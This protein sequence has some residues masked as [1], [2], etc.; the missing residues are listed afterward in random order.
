MSDDQNTLT[1]DPSKV[2]LV[3]KAKPAPMSATP[4][5]KSAS[6]N[7]DS[8]DPS[9]VKLVQRKPEPLSAPE[10][11]ASSF[12]ESF[13]MPAD[14]TQW[15]KALKGLTE[16]PLG[17]A[18]PTGGALNAAYNVGKGAIMASGEAAQIGLDR[19]KQPGWQNK[20]AG[21]TEYLISGIPIL[22]PSVVRS[23][24]QFGKG[25]YASGLGTLTGV[26]AQI[27]MG[28]P[29]FKEKLAGAPTALAEKAKSI[30]R[31][32]TNIGDAAVQDAHAGQTAKN[33]ELT[34]EHQEAV[35][36]WAKETLKAQ[37]KHETKVLEII[38]NNKDETL[39]GY[40][41]TAD[42][43]KKL[44]EKHA[45][46]VAEMTQ[47]HAEKLEQ[48]R[49]K[50]AETK[51]SYE[52][53]KA[54][55][56]AAGEQAAQISEKLP[57]VRDS[58]LKAAK[59]AYP[60]VDGSADA[61]EVYSELQKSLDSKLKG[62]EKAPSS[63]KS[64]MAELQPKEGEGEF[65]LVMGEKPGPELAARLKDQGVSGFDEAGAGEKITFDKLHGYYSEIGRQLYD[66]DLPGDE[67]AALKDARGKILAQ[68][69]KLAKA[70]GKLELFQAAQR[71][72]MELENTFF[73]TASSAR[74]GSP[75]ARALQAR[76]PIT[77][78][79]RP[80]YVQQILAEPKSNK[81]ASELLGR[82]GEH[83]APVEEMGRLRSATDVAKEAPKKLTLTP[84]PEPPEL[85]EKPKAPEFTPPP[86]D[87]EKTPNAPE[88][89]P[90]PEAPEIET[91]DAE[92]YR[93][94]QLKKFAERMGKT[95]PWALASWGMGIAEMFMG[96]LPYAWIYPG[97]R[98]LIAGALR[99]PRIA[100]WLA[101]GRIYGT[102]P[103]EG[104]SPTVS[105]LA[106]RPLSPTPEK[107]EEEQ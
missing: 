70:E 2:K 29:A 58:A 80:D 55:T 78:K 107:P 10:R 79:L 64:V 33:A 25:D 82:Y 96:Q 22:G 69:E 15:P 99:N 60:K 102:L 7:W 16:G 19:M 85:P 94:E 101:E 83:G 105:P 103:E 18:D 51:S 13:G 88:L 27:L 34:T 87:V 49:S 50:N 59:E 100:N 90:R 73:N 65:P 40:L 91:F 26:A 11:Y 31:T 67:A 62:T 77:G 47:D 98:E 56:R 43:L 48:V 72:W 24:E 76:D 71:K 14:I 63:L 21:G 61:R 9:K 3:S 46:K 17:K 57:A 93:L 54:A 39:E 68:M 42:E 20:L 30:I 84:E 41:K 86:L 95:S 23:Q 66:R 106:H 52:M 6:P 36:R 75:I 5:N 81:L 53:G 35:D 97:S 32:K 92:K 89:K 37:A 74:G 1:V 38:N 8:V 4:D 104:R 44:N 45:Q 28:D 12:T